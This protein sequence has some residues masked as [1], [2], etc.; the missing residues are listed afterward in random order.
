MDLIIPDVANILR[1]SAVAASSLL[2]L[3]GKT[4][5]PAETKPGAIAHR[6]VARALQPELVHAPVTGLTADQTTN[7]AS[8]SRR[9]RDAMV[10]FEDI[11]ASHDDQQLSTAK[12]C[13]A[14]SVRQ[15]TLKAWGAQFIGMSPSDHVRLRGLNL[16]RVAPRRA[17]PETTSIAVV[18][19]R[20]GFS[21]LGRFTACI[22]QRSVRRLR[23]PSAVIQRFVIWCNRTVARQRARAGTCHDD[24]AQASFTLLNWE[25][26]TAPQYAT[27]AHAAGP[28][29]AANW[30]K[31]P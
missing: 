14:I 28:S 12:V 10:R 7:L 21:A 31:R 13:A 25:H 22:K 2:R 9:D 17:D 6:E 1:P 20:Y 3:H 4:R 27:W 18:A 24:R 15:R 8:A 30:R 5:R 29:R 19:R 16:V 23:S 11:L 26:N